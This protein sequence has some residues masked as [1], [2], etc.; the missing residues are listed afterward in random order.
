[1]RASAPLITEISDYIENLAASDR[2]AQID[3]LTP[4]PTI[5]KKSVISKPLV[6]ADSESTASSKLIARLPWAMFW[7]LSAQAILVAGLGSKVE[8]GYYEVAFGVLMLIVA[9]HEAF[10]TTP[11]TFFNHRVKTTDDR[12]FAGKMLIISAVF[13]VLAF[14]CL[15]AASSYRY[16]NVSDTPGISIAMLALSVMLPFQLI[17]EFVRRWLLA[18]IQVKQSALIEFLCAGL[19][20]VALLL[21]VLTETISAASVFAI[22][23]VAN[24]VCLA[25]WWIIYRRSFTVGLAGVAKQTAENFGYGK[26]IAC[27]NVCSVLT[28]YFS[29]FFLMAKLGAEGVGVYS[30]CM[31]IV[32]LANPFLLGVASLFAPRAAQEF[33]NSGW[34]GMLKLF[35]GYSLFVGSILIAYSTVLYLYGDTLTTVVFGNDY[36]EYFLNN[37]GGRNTTTFLLSI[38]MPCLGVSFLLTCLLLAADV[39]IYSFYAAIVGLIATVVVNYSYAEPTVNTAATSFVVGAVATTVARVVLV[40]WAH[41]QQ[42]RV[43]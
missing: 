20:A 25:V 17:R 3:R 13:S 32:L 12:K 40:W 27:E 43:A 6:I 29:Q 41:R 5:E 7:A 30:A 33:N 11:L 1:M 24:L 36:Q 35:L 28:I 39:P 2:S 4:F 8:L 31:T 26:W 38:A 19:F 18:N 15:M 23:A 16:L 10:V 42:T 34:P 37:F 22:T 14:I 21:L 9:L